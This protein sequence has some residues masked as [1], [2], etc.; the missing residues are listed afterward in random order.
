M[1]VYIY[2]YFINIYVPHEKKN[3]RALAESTSQIIKI[4]RIISHCNAT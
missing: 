3:Q 2:A 1:C 4:C